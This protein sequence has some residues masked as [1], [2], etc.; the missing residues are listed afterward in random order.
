MSI[1]AV[2]DLAGGNATDWVVEGWADAGVAAGDPARLVGY[3]LSPLPGQYLAI[4]DMLERSVDHLSPAEVRAALADEGTELRL[5]TATA[6]LRALSD[7]FLAASG[8]PDSEVER[9]HELNG[10]RRP[11][12]CLSSAT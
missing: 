10:A 12:T 6:R 1:A 2:E 5:A 7:T 9:W 4:M 11:G 3:V 8:R